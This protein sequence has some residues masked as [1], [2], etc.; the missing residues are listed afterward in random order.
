MGLLSRMLNEE[1][2][3]GDIRLRKPV[4]PAGGIAYD[5]DLV[6]KLR[7]DHRELVR[8]YTAIKAATV[9]SRFGDLHELLSYFKTAFQAHIAM[10]NIRFY[11]YLQ[12]HAAQDEAMSD[13]IATVRKEMSS[14]AR[15]VVK[16]ADTYMSAPPTAETAARFSGELDKIVAVLVQR[17]EKEENQIYTLYQP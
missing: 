14:I 7:E 5:A 6:A 12:Q 1:E 9:A 16:F 13:F 3:D 2:N 11:V 8:T 15:A 10:E 4:A 17:V